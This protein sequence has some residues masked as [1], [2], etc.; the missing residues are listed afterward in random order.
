MFAFL[1]FSH[2]A[3]I[4]CNILLSLLSVG[5]TAFRCAFWISL[6]E[7]RFSSCRSVSQSVFF[8]ISANYSPSFQRF[9]RTIVLCLPSPLSDLRLLVSSYTR[10]SSCAG[11]R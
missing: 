7:V 11:L 3:P 4:S 1:M 8:Y 10:F 9:R 6:H 2:S 5:Y